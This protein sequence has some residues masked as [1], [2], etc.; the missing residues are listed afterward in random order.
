MPAIYFMPYERS[1]N[2]VAWHSGYADAQA[3]LSVL[4]WVAVEPTPAL[5]SNTQPLQLVAVHVHELVGAVGWDAKRASIRVTGT[6]SLMP[7]F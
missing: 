4:T 6:S 3:S 7:C 5:N 2:A 1:I